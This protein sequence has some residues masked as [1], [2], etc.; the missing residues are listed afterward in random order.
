MNDD[1]MTLVQP[2]R[3]ALLGAVF[4]LSSEQLVLL[5]RENEAPSVVLALLSGLPRRRF[6][7]LEAVRQELASQAGAGEEAPESLAAPMQ[8][9]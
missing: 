3:K 4:P 1:G 2:L 5:A 9:R 8:S 6:E 7:S